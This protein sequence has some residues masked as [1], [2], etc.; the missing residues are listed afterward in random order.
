MA[1]LPNYGQQPMDVIINMTEPIHPDSTVNRIT[2]TADSLGRVSADSALIPI[3]LREGDRPFRPR[4]RE[5][6]TSKI[7]GKF[8]KFIYNTLVHEDASDEGAAVIDFKVNRGYF[9][10]FR[11]KT[12]TSIRVIHANVFAPV[13]PDAKESKAQAFI[14]KLHIKTNRS[15]LLENLMFHVGDTINPYALGINEEMIRNLPYLSNAYFLLMSDPN[16]PNGVIVNLFARDSWTISADLSLSESNSYFSLFDR[17]FLGL[18]DEL[19]LTVTCEEP[20]VNPG[21]EMQYTLRNLMGSFMDLNVWLGTGSM[22]NIAGFSAQRPFILPNDRAW[23]VSA[24]SR[25][26][27]QWMPFSDTAYYV[28]RTSLDAWYGKSWCL[29]W[30]KGTSLYLTAGYNSESFFS[31]PPISE[32]LNPLYHNRDLLL[33]GFGY[34]RKNYFQSNMV[35]GYGRTEDIAYGFKNEIVGGIEWSE[36]LGQRYYLGLSGKWGDQTRIGYLEA[37]VSAGT[38]FTKNGAMQQSNINGYVRYFSP[39]IA[40]RRSYLR[41]FVTLESSMGFNRL[42]GEH[43]ALKYERWAGIRGLGSNMHVKGYNRLTLSAETVYFAPIYLYHFRFAFF[44]F[45]DIG[46]LGDNANHFKNPFTGAIGLGV[47]IK[48]E[49]LIFNNIQI[50]V[51]YAFNRPTDVGYSYFG[52]SNEQTV[53][54]ANFSPKRPTTVPYW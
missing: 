5:V 29:E 39:L 1:A 4:G 40:T 13:D 45:G 41:Q 42:E 15:Q 28:G 26:Q 16:N 54:D 51:G 9:E 47:R 22:T 37:G 18:G 19:R 52:V 10:Y 38:F 32:V 8:A 14:D 11:G 25:K 27:Y 50:R 21:F 44:G 33:V 20:I 35:Y 2:Q 36:Q 46:W 7:K 17:N 31:P 49:R 34:S 3:T 12:I 48:N 43:E 23:G 30:R 53:S 24:I 6:D